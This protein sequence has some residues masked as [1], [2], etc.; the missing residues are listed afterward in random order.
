MANYNWAVRERT[1]K[2]VAKCVSGD[3]TN[4]DKLRMMRRELYAWPGGYPM[5]PVLA[6]GETLCTSCL[7]SEYP[8]IYRE[9]LQAEKYEWP[10]CGWTVVGYYYQD[11]DAELDHGA[12]FCAHC[13]AD[14]NED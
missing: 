2:L 14:L 6:D 11:G 10:A 12:P 3:A 13:N 7:K 9:T 5:R 1:D 4:L 8:T